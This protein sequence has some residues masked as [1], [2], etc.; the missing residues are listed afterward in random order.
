MCVQLCAMQVFVT[1]LR[2]DLLGMLTGCAAWLNALI[3]LGRL[4]RCLFAYH[5]QAAIG[6]RTMCHDR[7]GPTHIGWESSSGYCN[8]AT[9][10]LMR[11][12]RHSSLQQDSSNSIFG[13]FL[14]EGLRL[15]SQSNSAHMV[16]IWQKN[17]RHVEFVQFLKY[18]MLLSALILKEDCGK[19]V[20]SKP[21]DGLRAV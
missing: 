13:A 20:S 11:I 10:C 19:S 21:R 8:S 1:S 5:V 9:P 4:P 7:R 12:L 14:S 16:I 17:D 6:L 18:S 15:T 2:F 3:E